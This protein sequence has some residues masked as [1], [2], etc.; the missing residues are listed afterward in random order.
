MSSSACAQV[1]KAI[2]TE[3]P[4]FRGSAWAHVSGEAK[5]FVRALL[6]KC[7][8]AGSVCLPQPQS[9]VTTDCFAIKR[10]PGLFLTSSLLL[11]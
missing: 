6:N 2:L 3:E 7:A 10:K 9:P 8:R 5:D 1:W 11:C 4:Q